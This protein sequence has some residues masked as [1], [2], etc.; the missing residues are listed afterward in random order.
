M[1]ELLLA[2]VLIPVFG[3]AAL[4]IYKAVSRAENLDIVKIITGTTYFASFF[5]SLMLLKDFSKTKTG[6]QGYIKK[7]WIPSI[8]ANFEVGIDRI[9]I[10]L[11]VLTTFLGICVFI[12]SLGEEKKQQ[13]SFYICLLLLQVGMLGTFVA[14]DLLLFFACFELVLIP[15]F[16]LINIWGG[17]NRS[18]SAMKFFTFTMAGSGLML[19]GFLAIYI[20]GGRTFSI[21]EINLTQDSFGEIS[22]GFIFVILFLGFAI[23]VPIFPFHTWLPFAHTDAPTEGSVLL[24]GIMLKMGVY[25]IIRIAMPFMSTSNGVFE[26]ILGLLAVIS[27]IYGAFCSWAQDDIKK[28]IAYSSVAHMGYVMLAISTNS[29]EGIN[30]AIFGSVAHGLISGLLF[31]ICGSLSHRY[32]TRSLQKLSGLAQK[33]PKFSW[34][35]MLAIFASL[36]IPGLAGF[37]GEFGA[38]LQSYSYGTTTFKIYAF[39]GAVGTL[40]AGVYMMKIIS[41]SLYGETTDLVE[42][43][44]ASDLTASEWIVFVPMAA[45]IVILGVAPAILTSYLLVGGQ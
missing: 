24:A 1:I 17:E 10:A 40:F 5:T 3:V 8:G 20:I 16:F 39:V 28:L 45:L 36:G 11:F 27:I 2:T 42:N 7:D 6:F 30:A 37:W 33:I 22:R 4:L 38:I 43:S 41:S 18:Y 34:I 19:I 44:E 21:T 12:Y 13:A 15:M 35:A 25:G 23:K 14:L 26:K 29:T 31:F 9:S 32:H